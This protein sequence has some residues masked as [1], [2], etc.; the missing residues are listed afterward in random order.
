MKNLTQ[1]QLIKIVEEKLK[2]MGCENIIF[3][4]PK[5]NLIVVLFNS[6]ELTSFKAE[7]FG[8]VYSGTHLDLTRN[9]QYKIDFIKNSVE[10]N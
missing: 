4:D 1:D 7:L 9:R 5:D 6:K 8:W 2:E 10:T 3:P